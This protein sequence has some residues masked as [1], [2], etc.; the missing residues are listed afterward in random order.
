MPRAKSC[1]TSGVGGSDAN[2]LRAL[3]DVEFDDEMSGHAERGREVRRR[4]VAVATAAPM[5]AR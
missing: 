2:V 1:A 3:V 5:S 4:R